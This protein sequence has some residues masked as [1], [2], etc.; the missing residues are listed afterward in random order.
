MRFTNGDLFAFTVGMLRITLPTASGSGVFV[1]EGRLTGLWAR[2]LLRVARAG[3]R[4][5]GNTFNLQQVFHV[6]AAG[7][8]ALRVLS[9]AYG[10]SFVA[11]SAYGKELC[12]RLK[13]HRVTIAKKGERKCSRPT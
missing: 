13:L 6:D 9:A 10:A 12:K 4:G 7:E 3:N 1:L 5:H 2:E 11:E 8:E